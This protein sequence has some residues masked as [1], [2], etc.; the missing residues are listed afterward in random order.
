MPLT[1]PQQTEVVRRFE[2]GESINDIW[3]DPG[4]NHDWS[5]EDIEDTIRAEFLRRGERIRYL[6]AL[7]RAEDCVRP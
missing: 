7:I 3:L 2:A 6:E 1:Q 4:H 5:R